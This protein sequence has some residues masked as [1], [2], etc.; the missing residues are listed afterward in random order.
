MVTRNVYTINKEGGINS[1]Y[2]MSLKVT[3]YQLDNS[4]GNSIYH[5]LTVFRSNRK[6]FGSEKFL[7]IKNM[8]VII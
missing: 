5:Y 3:F 2:L 4:T 7:I 6:D 8:S 1:L